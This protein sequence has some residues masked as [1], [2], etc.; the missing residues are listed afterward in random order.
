MASQE[1]F[2]FIWSYRLTKQLQRAFTEVPNIFTYQVT[3]IGEGVDFTTRAIFES[4][5]N[6]KNIITSARII[7]QGTAV[8]ID[9]SNT[10]I[11]SILNGTNVIAT[12]TYNTAIPFPD[13]NVSDSLGDLSE[14]YKVLENGEKLHL[15]VTNGVTVDLPIFMLEIQYTITDV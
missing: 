12:K 7:S 2:K 1:F 6:M 13:I 9:D 8:G 10:C 14:I 11:I 4:M 3:N 15:E 5:F